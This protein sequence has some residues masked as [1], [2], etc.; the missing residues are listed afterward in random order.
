MA[1]LKRL[2][3]RPADPVRT[4][5]GVFG[6]GH[7]IAL[8]VDEQGRLIGTATDGDVRRAILSEFDVDRPLADLLDR[9]RPANR[10]KPLTAPEGTPGPE[11]VRMMAEA[12]LRHIPI[13][14]A[15]GRV[16]DL[17]ILDDLVKES[18]SPLAAVV[19]AGGLGTR[20]RPLTEDL[21]KPM[22]P[23]GDRPLLEHIVDEL[24]AAGI[25]RLHIATHYKGHMIEEHFGNGSRFGMEIGY[26]DEE[27]PLGTAGA[28]SLMEPTEGP[29]LVINGDILT[30]LDF[31]AVFR[32]HEEQQ[33]DMTVG[34]R[35]HEY[36]VPF[37]VV[38]M[39]GVS[40]SSVVEKPTERFLINAGI[41]L[42][43]PAACAR[44]PRGRRYDMTDLIQDLVDEGRPVVGFPIQEYWLDVGRPE[45]YQRA[46]ADAEK[47]AKVD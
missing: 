8:V 1:D 6:D 14:D 42:L 22:L 36:T 40:V 29:L 46:I 38:Q 20:L 31:R 45:E 33:A 13:I 35:H 32:F 19:M 12:D 24:R 11:L 44:V 10:S 15:D 17:A 18:D 2:L 5:M 37:G 26:V 3:V 43:G 30:Q 39:D 27:T 23:L 9:P 41:Y 7:G 34:L 25:G 4:A 21:P 16:I 28:L 47:R